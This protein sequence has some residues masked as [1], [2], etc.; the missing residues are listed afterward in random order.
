MGDAFKVL[1]GPTAGQVFRNAEVFD[2][3]FAGLVLGILATVLVQ[4]S[5]TS[6]SIVISMTAAGLMSVKNAIPTGDG[7][8]RLPEL[9]H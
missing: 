4:S 3:P 1:G 2:N 7:P 6:T 5:S 9:N 8:D